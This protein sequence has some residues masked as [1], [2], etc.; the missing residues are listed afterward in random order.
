MMVTVFWD[1]DAMILLKRLGMEAP[2]SGSG[3]R[4]RC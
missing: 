3:G 2:L 1:I 4:S